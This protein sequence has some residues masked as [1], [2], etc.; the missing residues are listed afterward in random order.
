MPTGLQAIW[1][2]RRYAHWIAS[3]PALTKVCPP[4]RKQSGLDRGMPTGL[5]AIRC[6]QRYAHRSVA[7]FCIDLIVMFMISRSRPVREGVSNGEEDGRRPPV[8]FGGGPPAGRIRVGLAGL[9]ET[10]GSPWIL[11]CSRK[12]QR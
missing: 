11:R 5:Q 7:I 6:W 8:L 9:H 12:A 3:N 1:R 4:D 10:L 2:W